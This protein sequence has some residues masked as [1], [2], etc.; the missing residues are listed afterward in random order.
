MYPRSGFGV[1]IG[2]V[3]LLIAF[4]VLLRV[5]ATPAPIYA[6]DEYAYL[7]HGRDLG[8][9]TATQQIQRDPGLQDISNQAYFEVV[10]LAGRISRDLTLCGAGISASAN[11]SGGHD[12]PAVPL[13]H[14]GGRLGTI[15]SD[16][17]GYSQ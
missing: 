5:A 12:D 10:R 17:D 8:R 11:R 4:V 14:S 13:L 7:K 6:S 1:I 9:V 15:P 3:F 16:S 2:I